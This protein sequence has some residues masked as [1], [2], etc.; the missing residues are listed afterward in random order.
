MSGSVQR[1]LNI[2]RI[3]SHTVTIVISVAVILF[4]WVLVFSTSNSTNDTSNTTIPEKSTSTSDLGDKLLENAFLE[5]QEANYNENE[6]LIYIDDEIVAVDL[7]GGVLTD[8]VFQDI[9]NKIEEF[10]PHVSVPFSSTFSEQDTTTELVSNSL[11]YYKKKSLNVGSNAEDWI[12]VLSKDS[13]SN[14]YLILN[15]RIKASITKSH[16]GFI[17]Y[18]ASDKFKYPDFYHGD[19]IVIAGG[20]KYSLQAFS[21]ISVIRQS[22]TTLPIEILIPSDYEQD[23]AFCNL[24]KTD[25]DNCKCIYLD[26]IFEES[27]LKSHEFHGFQYKS[28]ALMASSF[29]NVL[30]LDADNYPLKNIDDIFDEKIFKENGMIVWPDFWRRTTHP[31]YYESAGKDIDYDKRLRNFYVNVSV[32]EQS[33]SAEDS[34]RLP[35]HDFA[36]ALPDP[37]SEA[38]EL[39]IN[40]KQHWK[41]LI[42]SL[43]YNVHGPSVFYHL[44]TQYAAGQGDKETFLA[45]AHMLDLPYYQIY[46]RPTIDSYFEPKEDSRRSVAYYQKDYRKDY[47]IKQLL[48]D[49]PFE[50]DVSSYFDAA[51]TESDSLFAHCNLP[52]FDF[53]QMANKDDFTTMKN[54]QHFRALTKKSCLQDLDLELLITVTY[55]KKVC[56]KDQSLNPF[57]YLIEKDFINICNYWEKRYNLVQSTDV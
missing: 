5:D 46:V 51:K 48:L 30:L 22:G 56:Q 34:K 10:N 41:S 2:R 50:A 45:S 17:D 15:D 52:K 20:G 40:K 27:Y 23:E 55:Y 11:G 53:V 16:K 44:F 6:E 19:G 38:G 35:Y 31:F 28:L 49:I 13:L 18:V 42:L 32:N 47:E 29:E 4:V 43:Y 54:G 7:G 39:L 33:V 36:G 14:N 26:N 24:L 1:F 3:R 9:V 37:S 57:A 12:D 21:V 8:N 25:F